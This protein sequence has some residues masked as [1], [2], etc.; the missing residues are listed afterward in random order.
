MACVK[1]APILWLRREMLGIPAPTYAGNSTFNWKNAV[2]TLCI[3]ETK[4][5]PHATP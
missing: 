2:H 3:V 1:T 4:N 5:C